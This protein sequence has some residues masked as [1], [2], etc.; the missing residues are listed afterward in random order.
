MAVLQS[1]R[2][3]L[4]LVD[5]LRRGGA[6][7]EA[8][9][10]CQDLVAEAPDDPEPLRVAAAISK[11]AG[12]AALALPL[13]ERAVTL[14]PERADLHCELAAMLLDIGEDAGAEE[15]YA[16][17]VSV[18]PQCRPARLALAAIFDAQGRTDEAI[19][20]FEAL[21]ALD[22]TELEPREALVRLLDE[23]GRTERA[24]DV[25]RET[26]RQ[27]ASAVAA[28]YHRIRAQSL[29][30]PVYEADEARL[31]WSYALL[32]YAAVGTEV[33]RRI[34]RQGDREGAA[35]EYR[36]MLRLLAAA[37]E[38]AQSVDGLRR[39]FETAANAF[40]HCH[41][42]LASLQEA[43]GNL[44]GAIYH[45]EEAWRAR[46]VASPE[47]RAKLGE[48]ALRCAPDIAGIRDAV[49]A[50]HGEMPPPATI[51]ITRWDFVRHAR[52]WLGVAAG[53][54]ADARLASPRH[55][56][57]AAFNPHHIQLIFA[58][59]C[60]LYA[61]C[62]RVDFLWMPC[63]E[64]DRP[65]EPEPLYAGW[66]ELL[67]AR[68][69]KRLG[70]SGLPEGFRLIDLRTVPLSE[71]HPDDEKIAA[72]Q[73]FT[74]I[75]NHDRTTALDREAEP[76]RTRLRNRTLKNIDAM[77]RA[78]TYF[79]E[80]PVDRL[81]LFNAGLMEYGVLFDVARAAGITVAG[82]EQ[83]PQR[84]EHYIV[85]INRRFGDFDMTNVWRAD[86]P[87]IVNEA[88]RQR[89]RDWMAQKDAA[90]NLDPAPRGHHVPDAS[91]R[92]LL[93]SLGLDPDKPTAALFPNLTF[94]T[95]V[96]DRDRAFSSVSDWALRTV[97]F[98]A[99]HPEWQL[100]VRVHPV[101]KVWSE[102]FLGEILRRRWP[103]L[104]GNVR[105]VESEEPLSSYRLLDAA[106]LGLYY[107]GTLGFEMAMFGIQALTP[108]RPLYGDMGFTREPATADVYFEAIRCAFAD[109]EGTKM[110]E[111]EMARAWCFADL[112]VN[113]VNKA[114]PWSYQ[115]F[116]PSILDDWPMARA[117]GPEGASFDPVFAIFA[118]DVEL[119]DGIVGTIA[120]DESD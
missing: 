37:A 24:L 51:P 62:H 43:F 113:D 30:T 97:A 103:V 63:L 9:A 5:K 110:T 102:E 101:E 66:D 26:M 16:R 39:T 68:E 120:V 3:Q 19:E 21:V 57:I 109:P 99:E 41:A 80:T 49:A 13:L 45:L 60:A 35:R 92:A 54:R 116:W 11:D 88:R 119:P 96:L 55:I 61:R 48:L 64:F 77:R 59:A 58:L 42:E 114:L 105:I 14:V 7:E 107:T 29:H 12:H 28:A 52:E 91:A 72:R 87:H 32:T 47:Q 8:L 31:A 15:S 115:R 38:Q 18:D 6:H 20:Q 44:G 56:A 117:L 112:Y 36:G 50:Y 2:D 1:V 79:A 27:A 53:V 78:K 17:A 82:W 81:V 23:T 104:P 89:I 10:L 84:A 65:C 90:A 74:D 46:R 118:G 33:A 67:L 34:E 98:F 69:M 83:A 100:V 106:Q 70:E 85:T 95:A 94:D 40:A 22:P 71:S 73:A 93:E 86:A 108:A 25:R 75:R 76:T 111:A 4:V